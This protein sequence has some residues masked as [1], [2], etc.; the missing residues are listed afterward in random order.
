MPS[1]IFE[2]TGIDGWTYREKD[3]Q[4]SDLEQRATFFSLEYGTEP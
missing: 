1:A 3:E 2:Q 4:Q